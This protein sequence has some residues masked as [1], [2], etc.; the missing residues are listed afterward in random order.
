MIKVPKPVDRIPPDWLAKG[1]AET[2][3]AIAAFKEALALFKK[4]AAKKPKT[5]TKA[6]KFIFT[7]KFEVYGDVE[8]RRA[9]NELFQ[10]KCAYCESFFGATQ[11]VA[12]EHYRPKGEI[13]EGETRIKPGYYWL[14]AEWSNLLP[15]CTDCNS[16]RTQEIPG[17]KGEVRGKGNFFPLAKGSKRAGAPGKEKNETPLLLNPEFD[18]PERH[19]EFLAEPGK[20]GLIRPASNNGVDSVR[21]EESIMYYALDRPQLVQARQV[22]AKH[23]L[24]LI[25]TTSQAE[26]RHRAEP[27][28]EELRV[29]YDEHVTEMR[30]Y[31]DPPHEYC[32]MNR[33]IVRATFPGLVL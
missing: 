16:R 1:A 6:S 25:K 30:T 4:A 28:D 19:L 29:E 5:G 10:F 23:L 31:L 11:P 18:D 9:L 22:A 33:Q 32:G 12:V 21:G 3:E 17:G 27:G 7:F 2:K 14:A 24:Y 13:I 15:S 8:L 20:V 26:R